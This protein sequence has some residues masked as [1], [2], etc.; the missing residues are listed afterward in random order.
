[1]MFREPFSEAGQLQIVYFAGGE[2]HSQRLKG[3]CWGNTQ[4]LFDSASGTLV[5]SDGASL[6][7]FSKLAFNSASK[8]FEFEHKFLS[9]VP[10]GYSFWSQFLVDGKAALCRLRDVLF[11]SKSLRK[12]ELILV[13]LNSGAR[14]RVVAPP[15]DMFRSRNHKSHFYLA[16]EHDSEIRILDLEVQ[17]VFG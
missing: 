2:S 11:H 10:K 6:L 1:M 8:E 12:Q 9:L 4:A 15:F 5:S 14:E 13:D 3:I 16:T 17:R 7:T